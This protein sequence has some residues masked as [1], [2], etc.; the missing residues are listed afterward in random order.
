MYTQYLHYIHPP[1]PF[2]NFLASPTGTN[3]PRQDLFHPPIL[4]FCKREEKEMTFL[5]V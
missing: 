5:L 2:S 4:W 3:T 1:T